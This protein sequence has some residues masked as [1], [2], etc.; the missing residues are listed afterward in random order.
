MSKKKQRPKQ[1]HVP[2]RT[3]VGCRKKKNKRALVRIVR[4]PEGQVVIDESGKA[5]GRGAYLCRDLAC[6]DAALKRGGLNR[7]LRTTLRP[8]AVESLRAQAR[9]LFDA[10]ESEMESRHDEG[11]RTRG[12]T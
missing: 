8:E 11:P 12:N 1:K 3:C 9:T 7:A 10:V 4:S 5:Q 6:W 2:Y